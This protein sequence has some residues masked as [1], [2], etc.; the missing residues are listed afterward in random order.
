[1]QLPVKGYNKAARC[2]AV[3]SSLYITI[4]VGLLSAFIECRDDRV[5]P[6]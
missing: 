3:V 4:P 1:L 5:L 2:Y 6:P